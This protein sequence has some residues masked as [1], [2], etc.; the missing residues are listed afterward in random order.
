M[1]LNQF[2]Y[3]FTVAKNGNYTWAAEELGISQPVV[4]KSVRSLERQCGLKLL[5][6]QGKGVAPTK[7]GRAVF[8]Y[9]A[10]VAFFKKL[11]EQT[12]AEEKEPMS[13][14]ITIGAG[15]HFGGYLLP[16]VL[17]QWMSE[18][19]HVS[20][21]IMQGTHEQ[22]RDLLQQDGVDFLLA[23][24]FGGFP[25]FQT[26]L[27]LSDALVVVARAGHPLEKSGLI[28]VSELSREPLI[29]SLKGSSSRQEIDAIE[30][31]Y[32]IRFRIAVEVNRHDMIKQ[33]C[34]A[35][36]GI[37]ILPRSIVA[38]ELEDRR[39]CVLDVEGFPR[40]RRYFLVQRS[41]KVLT[42]EMQSLIAAIESGAEERN[43]G[44]R[45]V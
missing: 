29:V 15:T 1:N 32:G 6:R 21:T 40:T 30:S 26:K 31:E 10:Q 4:Y 33:L 23:T 39:L 9:A 34:R 2:V 24:G 38:E 45:A 12:I 25:G 7:A 27:I 28:S 3:F 36:V 14:H 17:A 22:M 35:G 5:E 44:R 8:E 18:H 20:L 37:G 41:G 19:P 16:N 42:P 11:A 13:G 43:R